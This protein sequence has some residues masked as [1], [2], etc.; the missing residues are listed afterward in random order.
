MNKIL[1]GTLAVAGLIAGPSAAFAQMYEYVTV[2]GQ[3]MTVD[4]VSADAAILAAPNRAA[5]SGVLMI[6]DASDQAMVGQTTTIDPTPP[7]TP[8]ID[9]AAAPAS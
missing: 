1:F 3:I 6:D 4:A 7:V 2:N 5:N 8:A 9:T